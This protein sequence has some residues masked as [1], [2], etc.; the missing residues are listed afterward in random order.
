MS[1]HENPFSFPRDS[2]KG[3]SYH[4][5]FPSRFTA[6][7]ISALCL[8]TLL[9][10][11][12]PG[13]AQTTVAVHLDLPY[14]QL[15][16][17]CVGAKLTRYASDYAGGNY[18][19]DPGRAR[20]TTR[21]GKNWIA[22]IQE[23]KLGF[24]GASMTG[25]GRPP[26]KGKPDPNYDDWRV[27][28]NAVVESGG[29]IMIEY[30][31]GVG[32]PPGMPHGTTLLP[33]LAANVDPYPGAWS[34]QN[35]V[36][37]ADY[38]ARLHGAYKIRLAE[39]YNEPATMNDR[40]LGSHTGAYWYSS[41]QFKNYDRLCAD[42]ASNHQQD[43]Y[44]P[45]KRK[46]PNAVICG[47][48]YSDPAGIYSAGE[49]SRYLFGYPGARIS[50]DH[51]N[52]Q[53]QDALSL[54]GYGYQAGS[55]AFNTPGAPSGGVQSVFNSIFY[56]TLKNPGLVSGY[57]AGVDQWLSRLRPLAGGSTNK[58]VNTEWWA[59]TPEAVSGWYPTAGAE[60]SHQAVADVLGWIV[61][62]QNADRWRFD[63][64]QYH[65][66]NVCG[67]NVPGAAGKP[68]QINLPDAYFCEY[69]GKLWRLGRY[70]AVKDVV[71]PFAR[72]YPRLLRCTV[73]GP[74][75]PP[76]PRYNSPGRQI[77]SCAGLSPN[78]AALA[79]CL[80]NIGDTRQHLTLSYNGHR[81]GAAKATLVPSTLDVDTPL[82]V[83]PDLPFTP[84]QPESV[85]LT[86]DGYSA[87]LVEITLKTSGLP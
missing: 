87:A 73:T 29:G 38:M 12:D 27:A 70:Y 40:Q 52:T 61:H 37:W 63:A 67:G 13:H 23:M 48:S 53:Y 69:G 14:Y 82:T 64:L 19:S 76:S 84:G 71:N 10:N 86:L 68:T 49:A 21:D 28:A 34:P 81:Q 17:W 1:N 25:Q 11:P 78:G 2:V 18:P 44:I 41:Q 51:P 60:G 74:D 83:Q 39:F 79:M 26:D 65:A 7:P 55:N 57:Q 42:W 32:P 46:Y 3:N 80:A 43:Y 15:P 66:V 77:Q 6:L 4:F 47:A 16:R 30:M 56:P 8:L 58:F 59:Y 22:C 75:S 85:T 45:F 20:R 36:D 62:C 31:A 72:H 9:A 33:E 24:L 35:C 50:R 54:H 5:K